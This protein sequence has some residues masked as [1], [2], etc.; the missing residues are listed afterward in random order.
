MDTQKLKHLPRIDALRGAIITEVIKGE[1][2]NSSYISIDKGSLNKQLEKIV[3]VAE[4]TTK[5]NSSSVRYKNKAGSGICHYE[6]HYFGH[7]F[8]ANIFG[9]T[10]VK[11]VLALAY[12]C[13]LLPDSLI[14]RT[15]L[16]TPIFQIECYTSYGGRRESMADT[17]PLQTEKEVNNHKEE[18]KK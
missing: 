10:E 5:A 7:R 15:I 13:E 17:K 16:F 14:P 18:N 4:V 2:D 3:E 11:G 1:R 6:N 8:F 12:A 9:F